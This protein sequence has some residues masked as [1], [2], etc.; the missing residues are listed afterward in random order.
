MQNYQSPTIMSSERTPVI[1]SQGEVVA[2]V[3]MLALILL[4]GA[5]AICVAAGYRGVAFWRK[6]DN[7]HVLVMCV[8]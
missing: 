8:K 2:V 6:I 4:F 5:F 1:Y 7:T 3:T